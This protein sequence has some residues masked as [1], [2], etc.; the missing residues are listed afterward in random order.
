MSCAGK[1][2]HCQ[3]N[4]KPEPDESQGSSLVWRGVIVF[5]LP[6]IVAISGA[7]LFHQT[8]NTQALGA[9]GGL[10]FG[11]ALATLISKLAKF[12]EK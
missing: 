7:C 11:G 12:G 2:G 5:L 6:L 1:C 8:P 4:R 9:V 3:I 10:I